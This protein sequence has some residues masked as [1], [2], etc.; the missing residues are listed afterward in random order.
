MLQGLVAPLDALDAIEVTQSGKMQ[1]PDGVGTV[2]EG[3]ELMV[4]M[5]D[6]GH[7]REEGGRGCGAVEGM[8]IHV[9]SDRPETASR[10][11]EH[12]TCW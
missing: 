7:A 4:D 12:D 11:M 6:E 8:G 10:S 3:D 2:L 5:L 9:D 1:I